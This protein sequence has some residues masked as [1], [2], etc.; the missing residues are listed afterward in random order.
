MT[1]RV[2]LL[3]RPRVEVGEGQPRP[4][5]RGRKS[6]ALLAR[7]ALA[8]RAVRRAVLASELFGAA[9][10]P[11]AALRW[12]LADLRRSLD[13]PGLLRG[14]PLGVMR[15][16]LLLDVW[17]LEDGSLPGP[18]IGGLLLDGID[19]RDC[20]GFDTSLLVARS[21]C[22]V[23]AL[24]AEVLRALGSALVHAVRGFDG[25]GALVLHQAL[26][27]AQSARRPAIAADIL[28]ELAF[29]DVQAGR[30][31]SAARALREAAR[32][33]ADID[34]PALDAAILA[35]EGMNEADRGRHTA[36]A[37]LLTRSAETAELNGRQRQQVWSLGP[38]AR[39][40]LLAGQTAR[41]L[42]AAEASMAGALEQRWNAFLPWP[43]AIHAE[44]LAAGGRWAEAQADAEQAFA[45]GCELGDPCWEGMAGR[46]LG[47]LAFNAGD[48]DTAWSWILDAHG[49]AT[50]CRTAMSGFRP[51][52]ASPNS[53]S[54]RA[55]MPA[56]CLPFPPGCTTTP[57]VP[58]CRNPAPGHW[59]IKP[60]PAIPSRLPW[61]AQQQSPSTTPRCT[62]GSGP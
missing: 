55:S 42:V 5:P 11:L 35:I 62:R 3:G 22:A 52:S 61:P 53:S 31:V 40:L 48:H 4:Q 41:A 49:D 13:L 6:W 21:R 37:A 24:H 36:A 44:C 29:I 10:D 34:D 2:R 17:A 9:D 39:S 46:V 16:E 7:V 57:Q 8:E 32:E 12:G 19:L 26:L 38:L 30:H 27:A 58:T 56:S 33:A 23:P 51:T 1:V 15:C 50:M 18:E 47:L 28:R 60:D 45:L 43:Q 59:S 20:P 54:L 25:E 14:D